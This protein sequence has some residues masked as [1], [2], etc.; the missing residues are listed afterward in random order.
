MLSQNCRN[1]IES[2]FS[3]MFLLLR[4]VIKSDINTYIQEDEWDHARRKK[5]LGI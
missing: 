2:H 1:D 3:Y 5:N 4:H